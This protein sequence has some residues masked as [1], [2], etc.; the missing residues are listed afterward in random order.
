MV[1]S[2]GYAVMFPRHGRD[3]PRNRRASQRTVQ[4]GLGDWVMAFAMLSVYGT[5]ADSLSD[6]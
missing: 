3:V 1:C 4:G 2:E 6:L 5:T